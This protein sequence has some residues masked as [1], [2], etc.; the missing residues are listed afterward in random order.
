MLHS[1]VGPEDEL[2]PELAKLDPKLIEQVGKDISG[3]ASKA[4]Q[5]QAGRLLHLDARVPN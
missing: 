3:R 2:P 4:S 1:A 5:G